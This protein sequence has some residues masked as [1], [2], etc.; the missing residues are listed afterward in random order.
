MAADP[1]EMHN[2][3]DDDQYN[4]VKVD[5]RRRLY[6]GLADAGGEHAI[7]YN[8]RTNAGIIFRRTGASPPASFP[9][10][11][12]RTPDDVDLMDGL[13]PDGPLKQRLKETG[14]LP[15]LWTGPHHKGNEQARPDPGR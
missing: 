5:L 14:H 2:L 3:I 10:G 8:E 4:D 1:A 13:I 7:P 15:Q 9:D 11:W 12:H 6:E